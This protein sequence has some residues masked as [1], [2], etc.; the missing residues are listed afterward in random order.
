[1]SVK[2]Q[3]LSTSNGD[4]VA[5]NEEA[6]VSGHTPSLTL[7]SLVVTVLQSQE[8]GDLHVSSQSNI[9]CTKTDALC[10]LWFVTNC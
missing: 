10:V 8:Q 9:L 6:L 7:A 5:C 4:S 2:L 3:G 1:M